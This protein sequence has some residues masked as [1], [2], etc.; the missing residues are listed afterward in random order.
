MPPQAIPRVP[1]K[2]VRREQ[3]ALLAGTDLRPD[4][5]IPKPLDD[6]LGIDLGGDGDDALQNNRSGGD[7][8][9]REWARLVVPIHGWRGWVGRDAV[10]PCPLFGGGLSP[11]LRGLRHRP[12]SAA[13]PGVELRAAPFQV[14]SPS[15]GLRLVCS[16]A[17]F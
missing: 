11:R 16:N 5:L 8:A 7:L 1:A 13:E 3:E 10:R 17:M 9:G 14:G 12:P 4:A 2:R 15:L 6:R